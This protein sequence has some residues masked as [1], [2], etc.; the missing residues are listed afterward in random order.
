VE[1]YGRGG[2]ATDGNKIRHMLFGCWINKAA[3]TRSEF[4]IFY[5]FSTITIVT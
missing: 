3:D 4:A 1:N 2:Q 5:C